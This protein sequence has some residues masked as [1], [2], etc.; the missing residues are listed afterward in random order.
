MSKSKYNGINPLDEIN[1]FGADCLRMTILF[2]GP[3]EKDILWDGNLQNT[4][5]NIS[6]RKI[7]HIWLKINLKYF[8][9]K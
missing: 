1:K 7:T 9:F 4:I 8:I 6:I 3:N 5:V 2:S